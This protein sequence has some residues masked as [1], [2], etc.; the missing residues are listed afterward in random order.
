MPYF[1]QCGARASAELFPQVE[2]VTIARKMVL[3]QEKWLQRST[4]EKLI[5]EFGT[6]MSAKVGWALL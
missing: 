5:L 6:V 2:L 4:R 1:H 3:G